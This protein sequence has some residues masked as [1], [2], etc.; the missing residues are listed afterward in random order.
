MNSRVEPHETVEVDSDTTRL[1]RLFENLGGRKLIWI[2]FLIILIVVIIVVVTTTVLLT[3][4]KREKTSTITEMTTE[5]TT[6][7]TSETTEESTMETITTSEVLTTITSEQLIPSGIIDKNTKWK[8]DA[9][10]VAGGN[11]QGS[12]LNRLN[13]PYGIYIDDDSESIYIADSNNHRIVKWKF[14]AHTGEIVPSRNGPGS[15]I[16]NLSTPTDLILDKEKKHLIVCDPD[17]QRVMKWSL[18][19]SQDHQVLI[20]DIVCWS[21]AMNNDGDL[22]VSDMQRHQIR[23]WQQGNKEYT[24]VAGDNEPGDKFNQL[25]YPQHIFVD[26]YHTVYVIDSGNNRV[27]KWTENATEGIFITSRQPYEGNCN[28]YGAFIGVTADDMG[29]IYVSSAGIHEVTRWSPDA[30]ECTKIAGKGYAGN[31]PM[32]LDNPNDLSFDRQGNL[33]VVDKYNYRIQKFVID[34]D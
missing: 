8:K 11:G 15:E 3:R 12:E 2:I 13:N 18:E 14:G 26:R 24:V 21:L 9:V 16:Y 22:Y 23:R 7:I 32:E 28:T 19:N 6:E 4:T 33:Y 20:N 5:I 1:Q 17:N 29:N 25:N 31:G 10:T 27:M 34:L 30:K